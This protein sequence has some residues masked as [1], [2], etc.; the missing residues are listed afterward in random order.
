[1]KFYDETNPM[2]IEAYV[3]VAEL[4]VALLKTRRNTSCPKDEDP[5]NSI[6]KS[7][8]FASKS[9]TGAE[10]RYSN[11]ERK[12]LGTPFLNKVYEFI[13]SCKEKIMKSTKTNEVK[14]IITKT[15]TASNKLDEHNWRDK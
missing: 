4:W 6:F 2:Y 14:V 8:A 12:A 11:I 9:V 15:T 1:M 7:V 13:F 10:K 5:D 3:S